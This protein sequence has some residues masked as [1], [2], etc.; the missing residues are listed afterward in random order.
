ML[1]LIKPNPHTQACNSRRN[2]TTPGTKGT[3]LLA[4]SHTENVYL[5]ANK[6]Y[7]TFIWLSNTE[8]IKKKK[9]A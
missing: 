7:K 6:R 3:A 2:P 9:K 5:Q 8:R 1:I 4:H